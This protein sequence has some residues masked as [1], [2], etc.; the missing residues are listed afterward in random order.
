GTGGR[1]VGRNCFNFPVP[2]R[3]SRA[4]YREVLTS[5]LEALRIFKPSIVAVS[6]GLDPYARDPL[7]QETLETEDYYWLGQQMRNLAV[8]VFSLLEGGYSSDLPELVF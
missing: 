8:P 7:A 6:A 5:A 3:T 4:E 1:N 2:P